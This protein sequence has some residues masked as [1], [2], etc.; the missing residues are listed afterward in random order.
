MAS[1]NRPDG[2][3]PPY[4]ETD[5]YSHSHRSRDE[6]PVIVDDDA[7]IAPSS[8]HS[9]AI[10]T[11]PESPSDTQHDF[12]G[13]SY[14]GHTTASAQ[15]YFDSRP[16]NESSDPDVTIT[17][18]IQPD[19]TPSD[20]PYPKRAYGH[21]VTEQDWQTFINYLIPGHAARA[22]SRIIDRKVRTTGDAQPLFASDDI[23]GAELAFS[24]L[25]VSSQNTD[26]V[27]REWNRGFFG[28]RGI[29]IN[30]T[31]IAEPATG[32]QTSRDGAARANTTGA[33]QA[34]A[35]AQSPQ[36][37]SSWWRN[38]FSF[39]DSNNG[40]LRIGPL[41]I[42]GDRVALG[43]LHIEG[44]RVALGSTFEADR[45]GVRWRGQHLA[46][47]LF[48]ANSSGVRSGP[49]QI[50]PFPFGRHGG[51]PWAQPFGGLGRGRGGWEQHHRHG[52]RD[53]S[54][55]SISSSSSVSSSSSSDSES[56]IGSL[57]D[58]D[59]L[60]DTQ[61]PVAKRSIQAWLS[62]PDQPVT[63]SMLRQLKSDIKAARKVSPVPHDP[64]WN[65]SRESLR[66]E[67]KDM[68]QQFKMLKKQQRA[69]RRSAR[70]EQRQQKRAARKERRERRRAEKRDHRSHEREGRRMER[71]ARRAE[72]DA[73][74]HARRS[75]HHHHHHAVPT[76]PIPGIP[77]IPPVPHGS[78]AGLFGR[79]SFGPRGPRG[80]GFGRGF[81][82]FGPSHSHGP[83]QGWG[84]QQQ[85][86]NAAEEANHRAAAVTAS[87][88]QEAEKARAAAARESEKS[89]ATAQKAREKAAEVAEEST[90]VAMEAAQ[91]SRAAAAA[92]AAETREHGSGP[93]T[94]M[95]REMQAELVALE[96]ANRA[97]LQLDREERARE[98]RARRA[99]ERGDDDW[100]GG[101]WK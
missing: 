32:A 62:H 13:P 51:Q 8:S 54:R 61:L 96:R 6:H 98:Q 48:E 94:E 101:E 53:R 84:Q 38:P 67:I 50:P 34:Q 37:P 4:S 20:F 21:D 58:W 11:P 73:E 69:A 75:R 74:R 40:S 87:A 93:N 22:N 46:H 42:E 81:G 12:A 79:G 68:L 70:K 100:K 49:S 23:A 64:S 59:D 95:L 83:D 24:K 29:T 16:P 41:H 45:T 85:V 5:I 14:E 7:S 27:I 77:P 17:L 15:A 3:P 99:A 52:R 97:R 36:Q 44:D 63:K 91:R 25:S 2:P 86:N 71:A 88:R 47:P 39:G 56:S 57:P 60:K 43:P 72:R 26:A 19:A 28:P 82:G 65:A 1:H 33:E 31:T 76:P 10:D 90:R 55:S 30:Y 35:Q 89:F 92:A 80:F 9:N 18:E 66:R 78:P